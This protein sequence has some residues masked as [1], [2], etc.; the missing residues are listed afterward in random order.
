MRL[1]NR[2]AM[3][4]GAAQSIGRAIALQLAAAGATVVVADVNTPGGEETVN[5]LQAKGSKGM[6][7]RMD[8]TN[9]A[10]VKRAVDQVRQAYGRIDILVNVAG[11]D[12]KATVWDLEETDWDRVL[13]VNLKGVFLT[14]KAVLPTMIAQKYGRVVNI[15]SMAGKTGEAFTSPYCA[16][17]FGVIG[18]TQSLA[19][20]AG[21]YGVTANC[22][23][24]GPTKTPLIE[25]AVR[26]GAERAGMEPDAF[27]DWMYISRTPL[28][29]FANPEDIARAVAFLA[30]D[31]A[32][33]ITGVALDVSG[34]REVH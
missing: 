25:Q 15:S 34:G 26:Q 28:G 17:K 14:C 1:D 16:S 7:V 5:M 33:F 13:D 2:V 20:E 18:F 19:F 24:P 32:E 4:T 6:T 22:V 30:S 11:I 12:H 8:V 27:R 23:C 9:W 29:R 31:D 3:V 21:Q 10:E